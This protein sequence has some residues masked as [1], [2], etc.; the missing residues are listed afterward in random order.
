M[1]L[2]VVLMLLV[3]W[4]SFKAICIDPG[5]F[6]WCKFSSFCVGYRLMFDPWEV[7]G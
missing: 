3:S 2:W 4:A 1:N 7:E 5:Q 6:C